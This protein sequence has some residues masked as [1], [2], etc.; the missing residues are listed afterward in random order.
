MIVCRPGRLVLATV[1]L[2]LARR[3]VSVGIT[4]GSVKD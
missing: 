2:E 1:L 4:A 3:Y